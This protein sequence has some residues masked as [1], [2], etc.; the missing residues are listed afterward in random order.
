[1][2][3]KT[4]NLVFFLFFLVK[5]KVVYYNNTMANGKKSQNIGKNS[6]KNTKKQKNNSASVLV[7]ENNLTEI[8]VDNVDNNEKNLKSFNDN[9]LNVENKTVETENVKDSVAEN[10]VEK[11]EEKSIETET[12]ERVGVVT[13]EDI[14][15]D[16]VVDA[17]IVVI[18]KEE[19]KEQTEFDKCRGFEVSEDYTEQKY[20]KVIEYQSPKKKR[21]NTIINLCLLLINLVFMVYI[22]KALVANVGERSFVDVLESQGAKLWWLAGGVVVYLLYMLVQT[23]M[24]YVLIKDITGE[25]RMGLAYDVAIVG[26]YYDN[27][28]PFA[29]GGQPM[30]IVRLV[31]NNVSVGTS[32]S[33]PIIKLILN[34]SVGMILAVLFFIFGVPKIPMSTPLNDML[35]TLLIILGVIGLI[36]TIIVVVF[37]FLMGTGGLITRSFISGILRI[38]Y[39]LKIVKNYRETFQKVL[40]QVAEYKVSFK[41]IWKN[42]KTLIK[43]LILCVFE[44]LTYAVMPYFVVQAFAESITIEPFLFLIICI[45]QYYI[46]SMASSFIPLPG[47]T[48]LMEISFIF[49]FGLMVG[50]NVVWAL[51]AW[52]ILSYYMIIAHGFINE[53]TYILHN[54]I[55]SRKK[56]EI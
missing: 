30:Q 53:I 18:D 25:K 16:N 19:I 17:D 47:G 26:K 3:K 50:N 48:G 31:K 6:I 29:V 23:L 49:L 55:K 14:V 54:F 32:T 21:K 15:E 12:Q 2:R 11:L 35:L 36:I 8:A 20:Q 13:I 10:A 56:R 40:N 5:I 27:V 43:M 28:T 33:I 46:C 52:R 39:K 45:S 44:C 7:E 37:T 41:F 22:M 51:L 24:Y 9:K 38:G 1:M 42:K 34:S 4:K